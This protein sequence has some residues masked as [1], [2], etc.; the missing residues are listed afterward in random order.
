[1][2]EQIQPAAPDQILTGETHDLAN[3]CAIFRFVTVDR[4]MFAEWF[5]CEGAAQSSFKSIKQE[6]TT[7]RTNGILLQGQFL[8]VGLAG[9]DDCTVVGMLYPAVD[10]GK[11]QQD[12]EILDL[13]AG[14][15]LY[16]VVRNNVHVGATVALDSALR[17]D[18]NCRI[19]TPLI[20]SLRVPR[21]AFCTPFNLPYTSRQA[22]ADDQNRG[23]QPFSRRRQSGHHPRAC[24]ACARAFR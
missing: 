12:L 4:T 18:V 16:G 9:R 2:P 3:L 10:C 23:S 19:Q 7:F 17:E 5:F 22:P 24:A 6:F 21:P 14:Q 15:R 20:P 11:L 13:F 8:Q 1:M